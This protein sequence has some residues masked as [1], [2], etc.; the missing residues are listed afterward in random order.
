MNKKYLSAKLFFALAFVSVAL[1]AFVFRSGLSSDMYLNPLFLLTLPRLLPFTLGIISACFGLCC[2]VIERNF[3]RRLS[4]SLTLVQIAFL[5][6]AAIC[7]LTTIRFWWRVLG[8][9]HATGLK[10]P[11]WSA[12]LLPMALVAQSWC[13]C[14]MY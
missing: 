6:F 4:V 14:S 11:T 2:L 12:A 1:G 10:F 5:M 7:H 3:G 9:A 13:S 8:E